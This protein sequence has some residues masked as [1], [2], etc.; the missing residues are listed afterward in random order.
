METFLILSLSPVKGVILGFT[1]WV[2]INQILNF[3]TV[4]PSF[5]EYWIRCS[6]CSGFWFSIC[7]SFLA[8]T[9]PDSVGL[10]CVSYLFM[11]RLFQE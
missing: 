4:K 2:I 9:I 1:A 6:Y 8:D 11:A 5:L 10:F 7:F 3:F